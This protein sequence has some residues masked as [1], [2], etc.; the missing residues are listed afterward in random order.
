M[1]IGMLGLVAVLLASTSVEAAPRGKT[2]DVRIRRDEWGVPHVLGKTD[3]D[4]AYGLGYA[5]CEDD[6]ATV[7]EAVFTARG[8]L[9]ELQGQSGVESDYLVALQDVGGAVKRGYARVDRE[10]R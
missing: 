4:A 5:Q 6:F 8:R 2:W 7:Q 10:T 9:A 1:R 3:A